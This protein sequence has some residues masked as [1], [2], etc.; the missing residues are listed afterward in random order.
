MKRILLA[1]MAVAVVW[2][3][4]TPP[5]CPAPLVWRKGE[6]WT[7]ERGGVAVGN[8]PK[9]Q[10][11]IARALSQQ[12]DHGSA[13]TAYRRLIRR[14]PTSYAVEDARLGLAESLSALDY[15]FKAFKEYQQL[16]EKHPNSPHFETA[17]QRQF[18]IANLFLAGQR[19]K[20]WGVKWFPA[21]DKAIDIFEQVVKNGPY[22]K[23]GPDAQFRIGVA[24]EMLKDYVAAV[25][26][27]E[28]VTERYPNLPLAEK[29]QFQ[30]GYAYRQEAGRFEYDQNAANQAV[31]AFTDFLVRYP[32]SERA[33]QAEEYRAA[34]KGEQAQG[35]F[36]V[37]QFY[38]K[39][40]EYK[41]AIIY[42]NEVI[43]QNPKSNWATEAQ[44]K[45]LALNAQLQ[46]PT[47]TP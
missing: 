19:D 11:E 44:T 34:L 37:G 10:L 5:D 36:R 21:R 30:I 13:V 39:R 8:N 7:W 41:A 43:E 20:A 33:P 22:S 40:R 32:D 29:A 12:K 4:F 23:V 31:A 27:Y 1:L 28:K 2:G 24:Q 46:K 17:L 16:I 47:A 35:L 18:E 38:E 6:G 3:I 42:Y 45:V 15:H 26:A 25:R 9:E 14:W